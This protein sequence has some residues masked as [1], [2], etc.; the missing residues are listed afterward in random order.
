MTILKLLDIY[1]ANSTEIINLF[2]TR[3]FNWSSPG[4]LLGGESSGRVSS[5]PGGSDL[6]KEIQTMYWIYY[7]NSYEV[8]SEHHL[9]PLFEAQY[10]TQKLFEKDKK[11]FFYYKTTKSQAG[12]YGT[13]ESFEKRI[14][15][16]FSI[17]ESAMKSIF[18][19]KIKG[20][21][22]IY[23]QQA[24]LNN[25]QLDTIFKNFVRKWWEAD[26]ANLFEN[27]KLICEAAV[28]NKAYETAGAFE[29]KG[30]LVGDAGNPFFKRLY[31]PSLNRAS[32]DGFVLESFGLAKFIE[33]NRDDSFWGGDEFD[34]RKGG[35]N[36]AAIIAAKNKGSESF[37]NIVT[38]ALDFEGEGTPEE[39]LSLKQCALITGLLHGG[40]GF[41]NYFNNTR[42]ANSPLKHNPTG[43]INDLDYRVYPVKTANFNPTTLVNR[44]TLNKK[45][46][47][48]FINGDTKKPDAMIRGLFWVYETMPTEEGEQRA[49]PGELRE[50]ELATS[51]KHYQNKLQKL[52]AKNGGRTN[53][54][55]RRVYSSERNLYY[56]EKSSYYYLENTK[57][58]FDGTNP[59]TAR[60]DVKVE[61]TWKLG[62]LEGLDSTL[63]FLGA[64]DGLPPGTK[65]KV[66]DLITL[67]VTKKPSSSDGPG[68]FLTNQY[69]PNYS[70]VR[71]KIAPFGDF[72]SD[73]SHLE[74]AM[75]LDLAIIDHKI[76]RDSETGATTLVINY[77][78]YFEATL[79]MPFNDA[80]AD[81]KIITSRQRRQEEGLSKLMTEGC[82]P[83]LVREALRLE[84]QNFSREGKLF[85]TSSLINRLLDKKLI[86]TYT[87]NQ[88][89]MLY[90][91]YGNRLDSR[92]NFVMSVNAQA[93][94]TVL[95]ESGAKTVDQYLQNEDDKDKKAE[96]RIK[97][98][99][100]GDR[101]FFL[102]DLM[103]VLLDC[104]YRKDSALHRSHVKNLNLRFMVGTINVPNPKWLNSP[105]LVINP[106]TIPIDLA[107]FVE[108]C[109]STIVKKGIASYPVGTFIRDLIG[110][111]VNGIIYESCFSLLLPDESPPLLRS[112]FFT[113]TEPKWFIKNSQGYLD[114]DDPFAGTGST[115]G[116]GIDLLFPKSIARDLS[117]LE[118]SSREVNDTNY[119][120]IYQQF[121]S[122]KRQL[123][124]EQNK[125]L[126]E[127]EYTPT[128]FYGAKNTENN[129]I[130]NVSFSKTDS[131]FL[132][133]ARY[134]NSDYGGL[135]LLSNVYD[136]SFS[137]IKRK[138]NTLFY[139]GS[140][141][142]FVLL[143]WG[144]R[145]E[146]W[147]TPWDNQQE[148]G[149]SD[150]HTNGTISN[151]MG[152][153]GYFIVK[154]VEYNLGELPTEFEIKISTK[155]L[156]TDAKKSLNRVTSDERNLEDKKEC[157]DAFNVIAKRFN[158]IA[159]GNPDEDS[160][161]S[162]QVAPY[163]KS[164]TP[165]GV[166]MK[167]GVVQSD[168][169]Q[170]NR[171]TEQKFV[172][173]IS[174]SFRL[175]PV[176]E[177]EYNAIEGKGSWKDLY[178]SEFGLDETQV[179]H[180][181]D[182]IKR[183]I[184]SDSRVGG[185]IL[186]ADEKREKR[187][188]VSFTGDKI[189]INGK[190]P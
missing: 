18:E 4:D 156:G 165:E 188:A 120:V 78:G 81:D 45:V 126:K 129:F 117:G 171:S 144:R 73:P 14:G 177:G 115:S 166:R 137:F 84:Q 53:F 134:F 74:D 32:P 95:T 75:I 185:A 12:K 154:S 7:G 37:K 160:V 184:G 172:D 140:I 57:I 141:L 180:I 187:Y 178:E 56:D 128:I 108:W 40:Y 143:D 44:C 151:I 145:W 85:K 61:M 33:E 100:F 60:N 19:T 87:L 157:A 23:Y 24:I 150:P 25:T 46:K 94:S 124:A 146:K 142:N 2:T 118:K 106:L 15:K 93:S 47:N 42:Y 8:K 71:L 30:N 65:V 69:S 113:A 34:E 90:N 173:L 123:Q 66:K 174:S 72:G 62:S 127:E 99:G 148:Y 105:P 102:G 67:P 136:L 83:E 133:E 52:I 39:L 130:S 179:Q 91:T 77:R 139:P 27:F 68:Q 70:R 31:K 181:T 110:R 80:L 159:G 1:N 147:Y 125:T 51:S 79:G 169:E 20:K 22:E 121:P 9:Y 3:F 135:S 116:A 122:Y 11:R 16:S 132:R 86:H 58:N 111:L 97:L 64:D 152:L 190:L 112:S 163:A 119:C 168:G 35:L 54:E 109:N 183:D 13:I 26:K 50:A 6:A 155:F 175:V 49:V 170:D 88:N 161:P 101:F 176:P 59:S 41:E 96:E 17:D 107:F 162:F 104:L 28:A 98:S 153:G 89:K 103:V 82:K 92:Q 158:E 38:N 138:A 164:N 55:K 182:I 36:L 63:A 186:M 5:V 29:F 189:I 114:P 76:S 10:K 48:I 149:E 21:V 43:S 131:P 167:D